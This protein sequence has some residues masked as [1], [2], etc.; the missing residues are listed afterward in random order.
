MVALLAL[1]NLNL[2]N[3]E[4]AEWLRDELEVRWKRLGDEVAV[5]ERTAWKVVNG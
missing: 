2:H 4:D 1:V 3:G 5:I